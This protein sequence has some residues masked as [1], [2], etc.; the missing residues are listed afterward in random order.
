MMIISEGTRD[1]LSRSS[2][3]LKNVAGI[4]DAFIVILLSVAI[5]T[6]CQ[7]QEIEYFNNLFSNNLIILILTH[8]FLHRIL[9]ILLF[10]RTFG[11]LLTNQKYSNPSHSDLTLAEKILAVFMIY[12]NGTE[13]FYIR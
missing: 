12:V 6:F 3:I 7:W 13:C 10:S 5:V 1:Q 2:F 4:L 8:F 9:M 11:M